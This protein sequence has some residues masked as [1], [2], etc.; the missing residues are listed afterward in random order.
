M[1]KAVKNHTKIAHFMQKS[2]PNVKMHKFAQE[3]TTVDDKLRPNHCPSSK[4]R[5]VILGYSWK[6]CIF[7]HSY[8]RSFKVIINNL[9]VIDLIEWFSILLL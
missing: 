4:E 5:T 3:M 1:K 6:L 2:A 8:W 9:N 7:L